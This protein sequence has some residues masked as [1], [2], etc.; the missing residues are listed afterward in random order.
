[1]ARR[2][3]PAFDH[4]KI[5]IEPYKDKISETYQLSMFKLRSVGITVLSKGES[6]SF[7]QRENRYGTLAIALGEA[8]RWARH[9]VRTNR[10]HHVDV[11]Y[12]PTA[13]DKQDIEL[14]FVIPTRESLELHA[15]LEQQTKADDKP[16]LALPEPK[17]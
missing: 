11:L 2:A 5:M 3:E 1:M 6:Y 15:A 9:L 13:D 17:Q 14:G 8:M 7:A 16:Q 10:T 4:M 12:C